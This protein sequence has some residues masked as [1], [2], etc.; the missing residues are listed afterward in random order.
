M[1]LFYYCTSLSKF[2]DNSTEKQF[3]FLLIFAS[4]QLNKFIYIYLVGRGGGG[5]FSFIL[6]FFH[7]PLI[8]LIFI[9]FS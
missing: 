3:L 8:S 1:S 4:G 2:V 9:L 6:H 7:N 5:Y